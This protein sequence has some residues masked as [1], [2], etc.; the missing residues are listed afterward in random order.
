MATASAPGSWPISAEVRAAFSRALPADLM[1][2]RGRHRLS[3]ERRTEYWALQAERLAWTTPFHD[4][5]TEA[6]DGVGARWFE[7]GTLNACANA[8]DVRVAAGGGA[9]RALMAWQPDGTLASWTYAELLALV[10]RLAAGLAAHGLALGDRVALYLPDVPEV[11]A[12]HLALAR[13]G[14]VVAPISYHFSAELARQCAVDCGARAV[15]VGGGSSD[16]AYAERRDLL[17]AALPGVRIF[18]AGVATPGAVPTG[19]TTW[20]QLLAA[21]G[22]KSAAPVAVPSEHPLMI[23]YA[24]S[25][26]GPRGVVF[27]TAG[28]LVQAVA[29]HALVFDAARPGGPLPSIHTCPELDTIPAL[30][31]GLWGALA[32]GTALSIRPGHEPH[33]DVLARIAAAEDEIGLLTHPRHLTALRDVLGE[34]ALGAKRFAFVACTGDALTPRLL[35]FAGAALTHGE[36]CV[37]NLWAQTESG[38]ALLATR[39]SRE[40]NRAGSLGLPLPGLEALV[41]NDLGQ[42]CRWNESGQ[43]C[44]RGAWPARARDILGDPGRFRQAHFGLLPGCY[45][46]RDGVRIDAEGFAWY[47][48]RLDDVVKVDG[49]SVA[50]AE[51]EQALA[52]NP[53]V[54]EV[55][56]VGVAE[57]DVALVAFVVVAGGVLPE[58][59]PALSAEL[60]EGARARLGDLARRLRIVFASALPR[61]RSGKVVRRVLKRLATGDVRP[62]EDLHH[63][64]NPESLDDLLLRAQPT[65][66]GE[67]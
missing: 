40:L 65:S 63:V 7:G 42:P 57:R 54:A 13:L 14:L 44:F 49:E 35:R 20:E 50:T 62:G 52:G 30:A 3:L 48:G 8:L 26:A 12:L 38:G 58:D 34:S 19:A 31:H 46:T 53:R 18:T 10:D 17:A 29:T 60:S 9:G 2:A 36:E 27:A 4:V 39:P 56:V 11:V 32:S 61:T 6:D 24:R 41:V 59:E 16:P 23:R 55:A 28:F 25:A 67:K 15:L 1:T 21:G 51:V 47:M 64:A 66:G 37:L 33:A 22:G 43:L 45:A 5:V